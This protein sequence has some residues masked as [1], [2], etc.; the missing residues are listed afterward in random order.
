MKRDIIVRDE[1]EAIV[2]KEALEDNILAVGYD[3]F[4]QSKLDNL[5]EKI[6]RNEIILV[7]AR[8]SNKDPIYR[9]QDPMLHVGERMLERN[10]FASIAE[11]NWPNGL[12][13]YINSGNNLEANISQAEPLLERIINDI[14]TLYKTGREA[15]RGIK[16]DLVPRLSVVDRDYW[17]SYINLAR[18]KLAEIPS[19]NKSTLK[20]SQMEEMLEAKRE[21][22]EIDSHKVWGEGPDFKP[23]ILARELQNNYDF[24]AL[25][26]RGSPD[27]YTLFAYDNGVFKP[28]GEAKLHKLI[29]SDAFLGNDWQKKDADQTVSYIKRANPQDP[30]KMLRENSKNYPDWINCKNGMVNAF[31]GEIT[32]HNPNYRS[33]NQLNVEYDPNAKSEKLEQVLRDILV[34]DKNPDETKVDLFYEFL[35]WTI[36]NGDINMKKMLFLLG[37][38]NNGKSVLLTLINSLLGSSNYSSLKLKAIAEDQFAAADLFGKLANIN[39]DL[40]STDITETSLIKQLTGGDVVQVDQ[41]YKERLQFQN[42]A[43][44][45]FALN[46]LPVIRD[47]SQAFFKRLIIL[48]TPNTF[49]P[50]DEKYDP[51]LT[52]KI[53]TESVKSALLN[54]ALEGLKRLKLNDWQFT[55]CPSSMEQVKEYQVE[56]NLVIAFLDE[57]CVEKPGKSIVKQELYEIYDRWSRVNN[58]HPFG[59]R[60][61]LARVRDNP[62]IRVKD[63]KKRVDGKSVR[64]FQNIKINDDA[65]SKYYNK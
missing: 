50:G 35:G 43:K 32:A 49:R 14:P 15:I 63:S 57:M 13:N 18:D 54:K 61:F 9:T 55:E 7:T 23:A 12:G 11:V 19:C 52:Q 33:L 26:N 48:D 31:T 40:D 65:K 38:G 44:L 46:D 2:L 6:D 16:E 42:R 30:I 47:Y 28:N 53:T 60:K 4:N 3:N 64:L 1:F 62:I 34:D 27:R 41:K 45:Y 58:Y 39:G 36:Y 29:Q 5:L 37:K 24:I 22:L 59:K 10:E 17:G 51:D 25:G 20:K 8:P 21:E 56:A